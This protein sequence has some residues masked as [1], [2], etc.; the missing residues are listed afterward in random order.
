MKT[1]Q[2]ELVANLRA[3]LGAPE[4]SFWDK[5]DALE[6]VVQS[7]CITFDEDYVGQDCP[8]SSLDLEE[9]TP[10]EWAEAGELIARVRARLECRP[11]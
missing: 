11:R 3:A 8:S 10:E 7:R 5:V 1:E 2:S 6:A 9:P 4:S